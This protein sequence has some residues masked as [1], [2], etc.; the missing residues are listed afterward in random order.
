MTTRIQGNAASFT[1]D[2]Y[3]TLLGFAEDPDSP[4][5]YIMLSMVN[6]PNEQDMSLD[7]GGLHVDAGAL[8]VAG[9]NLIE[10]IRETDTGVVVSLTVDAAQNA[11]IGQDIEIELQSKIIDGI[12]VGEAAQRFRDRLLSWGQAKAG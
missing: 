7:L 10:D 5:N 3:S 9:Y 2:G 11:G 12:S 8:R 1:D 6:E 4:V